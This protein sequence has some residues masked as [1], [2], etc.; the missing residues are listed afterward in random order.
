MAN[1]ETVKREWLIYSKKR[2]AVFCFC[3]VLF[4]ADST[5]FNKGYSDWQHLAQTI[6]YHETS[7]NHYNNFAS[8]KEYLNRMSTDS[9]IDVSLDNQLS[10]ERKRL[11]LV[12]ER[13]VA[14]AKFLGRQN[15]AFAGTDSTSGN[16]YELAQMISEF[17][18]VME[19]HLKSN[20]RNKY[21]TPEAQND[22]IKVIGDRIRNT[23]LDQVRKSKYYGIILDCTPDVSRKEQMTVVFRY[24]H[25]DSQNSVYQLKESFVE[26]VNVTEKTGEGM[27][28][29]VKLE[30]EKLHIDIM[31]M[32]A[33]G[34]D[35]GSNMEGKDK[36]VQKRIRDINPLA[37]YIPC[38]NHTLN[39][40][41][42]D[43]ASASG[44]ISGFFSLVQQFY[45]F[46]SASTSRWDI[47]TRHCVM[48][49]DLTPKAVSETR[50]SARL[51]AVK[52]LR[53]NLKRIIAA[54]DE[55]GECGTFKSKVRHEATSLADKV[56]FKFICSIC[57]WHTILEQFDRVS[58]TLQG[59]QTNI[60]GAVL[61]LRDLHEF[62]AEYESTGYEQAMQDAYLIAE[63]LEIPTTFE[64]RKRG[65]P[66]QSA[67][68]EEHFKENFFHF[69]MNVAK[70]SIADRFEAFSAH[71]EIFAFLYETDLI[72]ERHA[73]G[74]LKP[75]CMKL[76]KALRQ[77]DSS[78][79][80][81]DELHNE[82][83]IVGKMLKE[84]PEYTSPL[85]VLNLIVKKQHQSVLPNTMIAYRILLSYPVSVGSGERSFSKLK[86]IKNPL[87]SRMGQDRLSN[88]AI[89]SIEKE[90]A[91][92][93]DY[94]DVIA[95]FANIKSRKFDTL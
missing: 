15:L 9:T 65:R 49:T 90:L 64:T 24:V 68:A 1:G 28:D 21:L 40:T 51:D 43:I 11:K 52:P 4:G 62:L 93:L 8:W 23:I 83:R 84:N 60:G 76:E 32:R 33:Q 48:P 55:I 37:V 63:E 61:L 46:L 19:M 70:E 92:T 30:L 17:D 2:D 45:V 71:C 54:L 67:T 88:L 39:L 35:H 85:D 56:D 7:N 42:N 22:L 14:M 53:R 78:D 3:C 16:F 58:R 59:I 72:G 6:K 13:L 82:L 86:L 69:L 77:D 36:G 29:S 25:F 80:D 34:Y 31:D 57:I 74:A 75:L 91:K 94:D 18:A 44:E 10:D 89:I 12:F 95:D 47:V 27:T 5:V 41:L 66:L 26:Y 20:A 50:W 79:I 38:C 81:G 73:S 87:R